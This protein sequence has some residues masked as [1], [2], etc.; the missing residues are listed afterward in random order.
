MRHA[1][2]LNSHVSVSVC[3]I[4]R[5]A[6]PNA[7]ADMIGHDVKMAPRGGCASMWPP[8]VAKI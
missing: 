3:C 7:E 1:L 8:P 5:D 4:E 6:H 2:F